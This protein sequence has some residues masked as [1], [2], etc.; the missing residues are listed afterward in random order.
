LSTDY[1]HVECFEELLDF[2]S[3]HYVARFE[4]DRRKHIPDQAAQ[5][6]LDHINNLKLFVQRPNHLGHTPDPAIVAEHTALLR[7]TYQESQITKP[8][9]V[10]TPNATESNYTLVQ[11]LSEAVLT[12]KRGYLINLQT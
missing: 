11:P 2:S 1:Y 8:S 9:T 6:I 5:C 4:P 3:P 10:P 12:P 7:R